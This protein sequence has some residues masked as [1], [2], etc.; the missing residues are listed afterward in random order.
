MGD[1]NP[2]QA[3]TGSYILTVQMRTMRPRAP[4][5]S[6]F[7]VPL[8]HTAPHLIAS[9]MGQ[10]LFFICFSY[11]V[12]HHLAEERVGVKSRGEKMFDNH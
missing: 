6:D 3:I 2:V 5:E 9:H 4:R 10:L 11:E 8:S 1:A 12:P 7:R